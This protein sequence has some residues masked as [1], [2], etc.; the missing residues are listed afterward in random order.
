M[1]VILHPCY[2]VCLQSSPQLQQGLRSYHSNYAVSSHSTVI[3]I[4]VCSLVRMVNSP[5]GQW[6][7]GSIVRKVRAKSNFERPRDYKFMY[8][9]NIELH[10][11][12]IEMVATFS[13]VIIHPFRQFARLIVFLSHDEYKLLKTLHTITRNFVACSFYPFYIYIYIYVCRF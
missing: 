4:R 7:E 13:R 10:K 8:Q 3:T 6:S 9:D 11:T 2:V 12:V 1:F 5:T